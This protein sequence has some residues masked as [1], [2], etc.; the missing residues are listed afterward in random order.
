MGDYKNEMNN[1]GMQPNTDASVW[2]SIPAEQEVLQEACED[3]P[4]K[5]KS[6]KKAAIIASVC[7]IL[8]SCALLVCMALGLFTP[9]QPWEK[10]LEA[11]FPSISILNDMETQG[12][13]VAV[14]VAVGSDWSDRVK[15]TPLQL[16]AEAALGRGGVG[17]SG[18]FGSKHHAIDLG[19]IVDANGAQIYSDRLLDGGYSFAFEGLMDAIDAS[20]FAPDSGTDYA[21]TE[22]IYDALEEFID[23]LDDP[24]KDV[25]TF[26]ATLAVLERM[27]KEVMK[28]AEVTHQN[29]TLALIDAD[30]KSKVSIITVNASALVAIRDILLDEWKNNPEFY[31]EIYDAFEAYL[32]N[33]IT[34]EGGQELDV[35][36]FMDEVYEQLKASLDEYVEMAEQN[37][38]RLQITY[39]THAGYLVYLSVDVRMELETG[40]KGKK[41]TT[42]ATLNWTFTS[43]PDKD[44][45]YDIVLVTYVGSE[46]DKP[47]IITYRQEKE[48]FTFTVDTEVSDITVKGKYASE[49]KKYALTIENISWTSYGETVF[50][51]TYSSISFTVERGNQ[52]IRRKSTDRELFS[53]TVEDMDALGEKLEQEIDEFKDDVNAELGFDLIYDVV[54]QNTKGVISVAGYKAIYDYAYDPQSGHVFI[55][56]YEDSQFYIEMHDLKT[57]KR[58]RRI[59][60]NDQVTLDADNGYFAYALLG[61]MDFTITVLNADTF[62]LIHEVHLKGMPSITDNH[63]YGRDLYVDGD[64]LICLAGIWNCQMIFVDIPTQ[65]LISMSPVYYDASIALDRDNHLVGI[66]DKGGEQCRFAVYDSLSGEHRYDGKKT[67]TYDAEDLRFD[68]SSFACFGYHF[69][70][71]GQY[72]N[73]HSMILDRKLEDREATFGALVYKDDDILVTLESD[74]YNRLYTMFYELKG[75]K[76]SAPVFEKQRKRYYDVRRIGEREYIALYV[77]LETLSYNV[78]YFTVEDG[79]ELDF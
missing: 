46:R 38:F 58:L 3:L 37:D 18:S 51:M 11:V 52:R 24:E 72:Y 40:T 41:E 1:E 4:K 32:Q 62:Q 22:E 68:G 59:R 36:A 8:V 33:V 73:T 71:D 25:M 19:M 54:K 45:S 60:V 74:E 69:M 6:G 76:E 79:T 5:K 7:V 2:E 64:T 50:E 67:T 78:E 15:N 28:T 44:A 21:L 57:Q 65:D 61:D 12:G 20:I 31:K 30:A 48:R 10:T 53:M 29:M 56:T 9:K 17:F 27:A 26:D 77:D 66:K 35:D 75:K 43:R 13:R 34:D 16:H 49:A 42:G 47:L 63:L 23:S 14:D 70:P 39:G 55:A